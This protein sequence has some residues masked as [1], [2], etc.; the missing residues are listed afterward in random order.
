VERQATADTIA[1]MFLAMTSGQQVD[2]PDIWQ[3]RRE[4]DQW[5]ASEPERIDPDKE[6]L[7][8]A[9]GLREA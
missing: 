6:A 8:V 9:L 2:I 5:L 4:F 3:A 1:M 7:L